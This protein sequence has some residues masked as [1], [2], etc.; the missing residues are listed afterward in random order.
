M[1]SSSQA[2]RTVSFDGKTLRGT[3]SAKQPAGVQLLAAYLPGEGLVLL[4]VLVASKTNEIT[5][6]PR[7]LK[8]LDLRGKIVMG[9]ALHT[10]RAL[11]VQIVAAG[12]EYIWYAKDNQ[13]TLHHDLKDLFQPEVCGPGSR[14][15]P[16]DFATSQQVDKGHGRIEGRT[17]TSS[18]LLKS[19]L[20]WPEAEQVF[21]LGA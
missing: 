15:V 6:A 18:T 10:Q 3:L 4:Q 9:D 1:C 5:A 11:S 2:G 14:P 21:K 16:T 17:L 7:M 20:D 19:N 12:G 8:S 13:P